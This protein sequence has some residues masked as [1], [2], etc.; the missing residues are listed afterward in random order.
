MSTRFALHILPVLASVLLL[1]CA[2]TP[3]PPPPPP[4]D[5]AAAVD[6]RTLLA[7]SSPVTNADQL[8][9]VTTG[10][11][12]SPAGQLH[13]YERHG[14]RWQEVGQGHAVTLGRNG[15]A[16]GLGLHPMPQPGPQKQEGD[17]RSPA[18]VFSLSSAFGYA[19]QGHTLMPYEAMDA[20]DFCIDVVDSP[21]YNRIIDA[22]QAGA[23]AVAGSTEPMRLDLHH[24]G[25][26]R[27]ALGLVVAHNPQAIPGKGS[28]IFMHLWR[29][30]D[31]ATAGCTAMDES[32]MQSL[33]AWLDPRRSPVFLLLPESE[34]ARLSTDWRLPPLVL[35]R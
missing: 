11:W 17:G 14:A 8:I 23:A 26:V 29:Q 34:Y 19:P 30:P 25:D 5:H 2:T 15:S 18:G 22:R 9:V 16:W 7:P 24:D 21:F 10:G 1:A 3:P 32:S 4:Q 12:D 33:F 13:R 27:Y 31:E 35:L 28:C 6:P 20:N